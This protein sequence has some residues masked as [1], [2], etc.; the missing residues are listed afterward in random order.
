MPNTVSF[1]KMDGAGNDFIILDARCEPVHL[2]PESVRHLASRTHPETRGC[3]QLVVLES[4]S[5]ADLYMRIYNADGG[6]VQTCGNAAR[7]VGFLLMQER[8]NTEG[9]IDT[10]A[11]IIRVWREGDDTIVDMGA[12]RFGW[13]EIP[14]AYEADTLHLDITKSPLRDAT[15]VSMGNPHAVFFVENVDAVDLPMLGPALEHHPIF[16]ERANISVAQV[17]SK[18]RLRLRIWERGV[19]ETPSCG[20]GACA[21]L[22]AAHQRGLTGRHVLLDMRGGTLEATWRTEDNH[23]RLRGPVRLQ[24]TGTLTL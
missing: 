8:E 11:G 7:C 18:D 5:H 24:Q 1:Q 2:T 14:L 23:I 10:A 19:G 12:P 13:K 20:T 22:A 16:P 6:E 15:C 21:A 4:S 17:L 3:D 9:S